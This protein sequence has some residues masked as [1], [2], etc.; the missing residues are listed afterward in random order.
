MGAAWK[1]SLQRVGQEAFPPGGKIGG[2]S[3][4]P[5]EQVHMLRKEGDRASG[6][7]CKGFITIIVVLFHKDVRD[8][9]WRCRADGSSAVRLTAVAAELSSWVWTFDT[10]CLERTTLPRPQMR[11][12]TIRYIYT[13]HSLKTGAMPVHHEYRGGK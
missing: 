2:R 12:I 6:F 10:S 8:V 4:A 1:T 5:R 7:C 3:R 13:L 11:V 9:R